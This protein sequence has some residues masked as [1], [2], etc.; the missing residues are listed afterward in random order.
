MKVTLR[1]AAFLG[2]LLTTLSPADSFLGLKTERPQ[3]AKK[4][5]LP[6]SSQLGKKMEV[7]ATTPAKPSDQAGVLDE[8]I[9][10]F[11]PKGSV[12]SSAALI[13]GNTVGA[14]IIALP[15]VSLEPGYVP[16]SAILTG[17]WAYNL[18][19]GLLI[20]EACA[21]S[22]KKMEGEDCSASSD[23]CKVGSEASL[24][25][26]VGANLGEGGAKVASFVGLALTYLLIIAYITEGGHF[27]S[28]TL[29]W[30]EGGLSQ[31]APALFTGGMLAVWKGGSQL[32]ES[33]N[34]I[35]CLTLVAAFLALVV[36]G[37]PGIDP[38]NLTNHMDWGMASTVVPVA[39]AALVY[40]NTVPVVCSQLDQDPG[41]VKQALFYGSGGPL[42]L[43]YIYN[44][45]VL[46]SIPFIAGMEG[47]GSLSQGG[48][49]SAPGFSEAMRVFSLSAVVTSF[50]G[51]LYSGMAEIEGILESTQDFLPQA[52]RRDGPARTAAA[53]AL[54]LGPPLMASMAG[55][56]SLFL[57]ALG[58]CGTLDTALYG[59]LPSL[60]VWAAR[61][62]PNAPATG[63]DVE[64][65]APGG[66]WG[67]LAAGL[68][69]SALLFVH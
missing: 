32:V 52:L 16:S 43:Y 63:D 69:S 19:T 34:N 57:G 4:R 14:G 45:L 21:S 50:I 46:G 65:L 17:I 53:D 3:A 40:Q 64:E 23:S 62:G 60:A 22:V 39:M 38:A 35:F 28:S 12:L 37:G 27:I 47:L 61:Y 13:A 66:S 11:S 68:V 7:F 42:L 59:L 25:K 49:F 18:F 41:K 8:E 33:A 26:V 9:V 36:A 55:S 24:L 51:S 2:L 15:L 48:L 1:R 54:L 67:V 29:G 5:P 31:I 20:A 30:G 10:S 6:K 44:F 58:A 56:A